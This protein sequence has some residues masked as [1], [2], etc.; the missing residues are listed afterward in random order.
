M[1]DGSTPMPI[2]K[3]AGSIVTARR[4][5]MGILRAMK[6]CMT[7]WPAIVPTAELDSPD[8]SNA[9]AK[10]VLEAPPRIG[11]SVLCAPSSESTLC[12][13]LLKKTLA[14]MISMA[15]LI[16]P[17]IV[18]AITTSMRVK[19][20]SRRASSSFWGTTRCCMSAECR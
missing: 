4:T 17:A 18:I 14:A 2:T 6:P 12:R 11:D 3:N 15:M 13:P 9:S 10:S 16:T 19:R 8:P 5:K 7:T 1:R 20:I